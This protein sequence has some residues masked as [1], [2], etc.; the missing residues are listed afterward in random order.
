M[1][2]QKQLLIIILFSFI[3]FLTTLSSQ[4]GADEKQWVILHDNIPQ[5]AER[6]NIVLEFTPSDSRFFDVSLHGI[7]S[8]EI[9][10]GRKKDEYKQKINFG[11]ALDG[12]QYVMMVK[13]PTD[14]NIGQDS[15][16]MYMVKVLRIKDNKETETVKEG[17]LYRHSDLEIA[18][19]LSPKKLI[20]PFKDPVIGQLEVSISDDNYPIYEGECRTVFNGT[21]AG[22]T[23]TKKAFLKASITCKSSLEIKDRDIALS[24]K[25]FDEQGSSAS[26]K[27]KISGTMTLGSAK[28]VVEKIASDSSELVLAILDGDITPVKNTDDA[29]AIV[30]KPFPS[31]ARVELLKRQ[32]LTLSDLTKEAGETGY[33]VLVFGDFKRLMPEYYDRRL[34][35]RSLSLDEMMIS[36]ILKKDCE[37][38]VVICFVCQQLSV[39]DLYEKWLGK[40]PGFY[41]LSDFS[42]PLNIQ[43]GISETNQHMLRNIDAVETLR[44][45]LKFENQK[46]VTALIDGNQGLVYLNPDA[47]NSLSGSLVQINN[48]IKDGKKAEKQD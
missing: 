10:G 47:G 41:V 18:I 20:I 38:P 31:F 43:F 4:A 42:D 26:C 13:D 12:N 33:V 36:D 11:V 45:K 15:N 3:A 27:G 40:D 32:L 19:E 46:V 34:P 22:S 14:M 16:R 24:L 25:P 44:G 21:L 37:K 8:D 5:E 17:L 35:S 6:F 29:Q 39:S 2:L 7:K 48:M 28:L 23:S 1:R 9:E 30:G